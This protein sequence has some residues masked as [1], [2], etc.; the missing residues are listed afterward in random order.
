VTNI[1]TKYGDLSLPLSLPKNKIPRG[2]LSR[3]ATV[4]D[5]VVLSSCRHVVVVVVAVVVVV[6]VP[7]VVVVMWWWCLCC[8]GRDLYAGHSRVFTKLD[9]YCAQR[10]FFKTLLRAVIL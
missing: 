9:L 1:P 3:M 10:S 6:V 2:P 4:D 5:N 7:L 8:G